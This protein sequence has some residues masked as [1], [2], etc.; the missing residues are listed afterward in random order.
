MLNLVEKFTPEA[1]EA[2]DEGVVALE[3]VIVAAA[4]AAALGVIWVAF[5]TTL[6]DKLEAIVDAI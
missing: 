6:N 1:A 3:Y 4:V 5:G 2:T